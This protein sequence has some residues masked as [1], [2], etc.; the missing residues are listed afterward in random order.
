MHIDFVNKLRFSYLQAKKT[1]KNVPI[2]MKFARI[3]TTDF[4]FS[5]FF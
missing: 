4:F 1:N 5:L 2:I 3:P